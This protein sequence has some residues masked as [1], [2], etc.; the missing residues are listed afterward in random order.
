MGR[1]KRR[2][3]TLPIGIYI[4]KHD[5]DIAAWFNLLRGTSISAAKWIHV[6]LAAER[7]GLEIDI[8]AVQGNAP[9]KQAPPSTVNNLPQS[10]LTRPRSVNFGSGSAAPTSAEPKAKTNDRINP[11]GFRSGW[12]VKGPDGSYIYGSIVSITISTPETMELIN[13]IWRNNRE[14][15]TYLKALIRKHLKK[16]AQSRP[17]SDAEYVRIRDTYLIYVADQQY[18]SKSLFLFGK[19]PGSPVKAKKKGQDDKDAEVGAQEK[20]PAPARMPQDEPE[21]TSRSPS[22][23]EEKPSQS[24]SERLI[25]AIPQKPLG[26]NPLLSHISH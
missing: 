22:P 9:P 6:L 15:S 14:F 17:P 25:E 16:E 11:P 1:R 5:L 7:M 2:L 13:R 26:K 23:G 3:R 20:P 8:G 21:D 12:E 19:Q 24:G 10:G 4:G 18:D